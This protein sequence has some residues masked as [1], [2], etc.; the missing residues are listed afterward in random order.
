[1]RL[2]VS[3]GKAAAHRKGEV[4]F[5]FLHGSFY[6]PEINISYSAARRPDKDDIVDSV[7]FV[8][9]DGVRDA[10]KGNK[11]NIPLHEEFVG[12]T[13]NASYDHRMVLRHEDSNKM[14]SF[15]EYVKFIGD[16]L[17]DEMGVDTSKM[18][19]YM[20]SSDRTYRETVH[21][22]DLMNNK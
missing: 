8:L 22:A 12:H 1:M 2:S 13:H 5:S 3:L 16:R 17:R 15:S 11:P 9:A 4:D 19:V 14:V 21:Y 20:E 6:F 18:L 10:Y 7:E